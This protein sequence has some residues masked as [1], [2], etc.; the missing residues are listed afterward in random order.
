MFPLDLVPQ[1]WHS[2]A[3]CQEPGLSLVSRDLLER[4]ETIGLPEVT[5]LIV[6][7]YKLCE[8]PS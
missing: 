7:G 8:Q 2:Y 3:C 4:G 6:E 1:S 5:H